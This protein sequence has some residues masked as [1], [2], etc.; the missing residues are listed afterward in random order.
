MNKVDW[1]YSRQEDYAE[2]FENQN[3][4]III[5]EREGSKSKR[6]VVGMVHYRFMFHLSVHH[7]K[8]QLIKSTSSSQSSSSSS[9]SSQSSS[10]H[11][12]GSDE[13]N[14]CTT[15]SLSQESICT[16]TPTPT[17]TSRPATRRS[18]SRTQ[19]A[20]K[21]CEAL[22]NAADTQTSPPQHVG[23]LYALQVVGSPRSRS[24]PHSK[25]LQPEPY[26][27]TLLFALACQHALEMG[28]TYMLCDATET[29]VNYFHQVFGMQANDQTN[30]QTNA[31]VTSQ[32]EIQEK[33]VPM[34]LKLQAFNYHEFCNPALCMLIEII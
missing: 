2:V 12:D 31:E 19:S 20:F 17:P 10:Y 29:S 30:D 13:L 11:E 4:F 25:S 26:T 28:M 32:K 8:S 16:P 15:S 14:H 7:Q 27:G 3:D 18:S 21:R 6:K 22:L 9:S 33:R 5:A 23:Y 34:Q 1:L 24:T